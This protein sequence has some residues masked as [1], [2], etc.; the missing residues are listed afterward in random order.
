M[1]YY[2][3]T[4]TLDTPVT[5]KSY[6]MV[7]RKDFSGSTNFGGSNSAA[8]AALVDGSNNN[9]GYLLFLIEQNFMNLLKM[10]PQEVMII[11]MQMNIYKEE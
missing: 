9:L 10:E 11:Y 5:G 8:L 2:E 4:L 7:V 1:L 3:I 6:I